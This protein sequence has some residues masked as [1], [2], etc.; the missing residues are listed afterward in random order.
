[1]KIVIVF[2]LRKY[3]DNACS[4]LKLEINLAYM[5]TR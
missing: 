4:Q 2:L 5:I 3:V 1:M